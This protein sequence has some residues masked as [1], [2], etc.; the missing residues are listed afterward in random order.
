MPRN[1]GKAARPCE[2][3]NATCGRVTRYMEDGKHLC[4]LHRKPTV[5]K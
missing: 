2:H 4:K 5:K 3:G 1:R